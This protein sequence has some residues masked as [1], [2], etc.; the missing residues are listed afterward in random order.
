FT[1]SGHGLGRSWTDMDRRLRPQFGSRNIWDRNL[2]PG[3]DSWIWTA[4]RLPSLGPDR[5]RL[6][7][8]KPRL[9]VLRTAHFSVTEFLLKKFTSSEAN[10]AAA[11]VCITLLCCENHGN[12]KNYALH[13]YAMGNWPEHIRLSDDIDFDGSSTLAKLQTIFFQPSRAFSKWLAAAHRTNWMYHFDLASNSPQR[14]LNPLWVICYLGLWNIFKYV[15]RSNPDFTMKNSNGMT[16][17]HSIVRHGYSEGTKLLLDQ[18]GV[19]LQLNAKDKRGITPLNEAASAG[20]EAIV[21]LI[22][23]QEGVDINAKDNS[24]STPLISAASK[25]YEAVVRLCLQQEGVDINAK[26]D[27]GRTPRGRGQA[28]SP[29][30]RLG[31]KHQRQQRLHTALCRSK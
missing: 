11:E 2:G 21:R 31:H 16:P 29:A 25:G 10:T 4:G 7:V 18:E 26:T 28:D 20:H 1:T 12:I 6:T 3:P 19:N 22:L 13:D 27:Y 14:Q 8:E 23:Q 9:G 30:G 17:L 5:D 15:L 24:G